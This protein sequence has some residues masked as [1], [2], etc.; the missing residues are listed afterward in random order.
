MDSFELTGVRKPVDD[1][2]NFG[3]HPLFIVGNSAPLPLPLPL[4]EPLTL[5]APLPV[6]APT[7]SEKVSESRTITDVVALKVEDGEEVTSNPDTSMASVDQVRQKHEKRG[8][9]RRGLIREFPKKKPD[10][11]PP[12]RVMEARRRKNDPRTIDLVYKIFLFHAWMSL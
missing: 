12:G 2:V 4:P 1:D 7:P 8:R 9:K 11:Q 6:L 10:W 5:P 3:H